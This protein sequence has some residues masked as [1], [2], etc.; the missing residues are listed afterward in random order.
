VSDIAVVW[1]ALGTPT[2]PTPGA[3]RPFLREF[4][5]DRRIVNMPAGLWRAILEL[6]IL[7]RR[8]KVSAGKYASIWGDDGSPLLAITRRQVAALADDLAGRGLDVRVEWAVRYGRRSIGDVLT[9]L[10]ADGVRR[11]L[12]VPAYP[13]YSATTVGSV[14][15][16]VA[17]YMM[18]VTDQME[19]RLVRSFYTNQR[20][21]E[22]LATR[23]ESAWDQWGRPDFT[24]GD[25]LLASYHGVP[26]AVAADGDPYPDECLAT[27]QA[28]RARL[29][30][31][32]VQCRMTYQSKFGPAAWL[33]PATIDTVGE[34]G[35]AGVRR[36]DVVCP[37]FAADC[38]ETLEEIGLLNR[39]RFEVA[40]GRGGVFNRVDCLNDQP[41]FIEALSE[42]VRQGLAGWCDDAG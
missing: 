34:L 28:L 11:V 17:R 3:V 6:F 23:V 29:G 36:I 1:V 9:Q 26:V 14:Y 2:A 35:A 7:P 15:D 42:V 38:L 5:S 4:L 32:D 19:L 18:G 41:A 31:D 40:T 12:V 33:T 8:A 22:A 20:Y 27:T 21:I 24:A 13:Q 16:A 10:H 37:G 25:V 39:K 30:L